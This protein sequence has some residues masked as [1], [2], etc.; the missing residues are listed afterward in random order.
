MRHD[1]A[2]K[3]GGVD[4][5]HSF[6]SPVELWLG[7]INVMLYTF[8]VHSFVNPIVYFGEDGGNVISV[9]LLF[10][11]WLLLILVVVNLLKL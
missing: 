2:P 1:V 10:V 5:T 9:S 8:V 4:H 7:L 11:V 3:E 6:G